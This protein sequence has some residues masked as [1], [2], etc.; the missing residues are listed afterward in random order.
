MT[1][2]RIWVKSWRH[3]HSAARC[4]VLNAL[5]WELTTPSICNNQLY[6][7]VTPRVIVL[8][9]PS[10]LA[11][12]GLHCKVSPHFGVT[13]NKQQNISYGENNIWNCLIVFLSFRTTSVSARHFVFEIQTKQYHW[14]AFET[15]DTIYPRWCKITASPYM[16]KIIDGKSYGSTNKT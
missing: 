13:P 11:T 4:H 3:S 6:Y 5:P 1:I 16:M 8:W 2:F 10:H 14:V 12:T 7:K 9:L 15:T